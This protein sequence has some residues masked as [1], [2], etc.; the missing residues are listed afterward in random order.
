MGASLSSDKTQSPVFKQIFTDIVRG[1]WIEVAQW[2]DQITAAAVDNDEDWIWLQMED[3]DS[4]DCTWNE[5]AY[6][7]VAYCLVSS[8]KFSHRT[9]VADKVRILL[10]LY[11]EQQPQF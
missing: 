8:P 3:I 10:T 9:E 5:C 2:A 1:D 4:V 11:A 6:G 7:N